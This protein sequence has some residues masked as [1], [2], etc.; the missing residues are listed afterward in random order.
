MLD[1]EAQHMRQDERV[2]E[3]M[4]NVEMTAERVGERMDGGDGRIGEGLAGEHGAE[5]HFAPRLDVATVAHGSEQRAAHQRQRLAR[6]QPRDGIAVGVQRGIGLDG[7]DHGV[8]AGR[9]GDMRRQAERQRGI[10]DGDVG[11]KHRRDDAHLLAG[12]RRDDRDRRDLRAGAGR[13]RNEDERQPAAL[14]LADAIDVVEPLLAAREHRDQL[15]DIERGAAAEADDARDGSATR[16][17]GGGVD[18]GLGRV[19]LD[20]GEEHGLDPGRGEAGDGAIDDAGTDHAGIGDEHDAGADAL[21]RHRAERVKSAGAELDAPG[22][23]ED[24]GLHA[25]LAVSWVC[26]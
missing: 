4:R 17:G 5:Q 8:D 13:G 21:A 22:R 24:E 1:V 14:D 23:A 11:E 18:H 20:I 3:T 19:G 16:F 2:R 15:G 12:R 7:M 26:R 10:E 25:L 6:Q 9:R